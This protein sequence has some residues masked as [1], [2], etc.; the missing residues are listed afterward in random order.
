MKITRKSL[1]AKIT[2]ILVL[3]ILAVTAV[4]AGVAYVRTRAKVLDAYKEK[5]GEF[6]SIGAELAR[7]QIENE[8]DSGRHKLAEFI[9]FKY[10]ELSVG[11]C[12]KLWVRPEDR[13][14]LPKDY[15]QKV[16]ASRE[17]RK[18]GSIDSFQR[19]MPEYGDDEQFAGRM[20]RLVDG[21]LK[22]PEVGITALMDKNGLVPF[23]NSRNS[24]KLTGDLKKDI[25]GSR[26]NRIWDYLGK[27]FEPDRIKSADYVRDTGEVYINSYAP[28]RIKGQFW[29]GVIL[30]YYAK[31]VNR[32][33]VTETIFTVSV[34]L[35][36]AVI[37]FIA[38]NLLITRNL[39]PIVRV[40]EILKEVARGD[41]TRRVDYEG[42]DEVGMISTNLNIMIEQ[43]SRTIEF[44]KNAA[45]SL[46]ASSEELTSTSMTMG[47]SST[48]QAGSVREITVELNLVLD[49]L[50]ETT[51][52]INEQVEDVSRA[53]ESISSLE[54]MSKKIAGNMQ[55]VRDQS[56]R[57]MSI[58]RDGESMGESTA[59]A[60][61]LIVESSKRITDMVNIINDISD[62]INLLS[63]NASIEA[64]RAGDA[65]RG[66]AVVADE[67]GKLADNTS[68]QV[69]EIQ[70][71][72]TEIEHNVG[73]GSQMVGKIR[74][75]IATIMQIIE[76]NSNLIEEIAGLSNQQ[77][78]NH[79]RIREVMSRLEEKAANIIKVSEFQ[80]SN[81]ESMKD[82]M[83]RIQEFASE[84]ASGAEEIA[85]SSE[86]LSSRAEGLHQ[87]IEGFKTLTMEELDRKDG[88]GN[89]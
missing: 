36:G 67:I 64:A 7:E 48:A 18:D 33:I 16:F 29:G 3:I 62:K 81:S 78:D 39:R 2:F 27:N 23:H 47:S 66:F 25:E 44:L 21:F 50:K 4:M 17:T 42:E 22:V 74:Q 31:D 6:A 60:M 5:A 83:R 84:N 52:Y 45:T 8:I 41:F 82:A 12:V 59:D 14:R 88:A 86:E 63:L 68:R 40:S 26:T 20:R 89:S 57:S 10:K 32:Q 34:I 43:S 54:D 58:S 80:R 69:K 9:N 30:A 73:T 72:S 79:N 13:E 11:E 37:I 24:Q 56:A 51:E 46:A 35:I 76:N 65:G 55:V 15:L 1:S 38:L 85:A 70:T 53:A 77:A 19:F 87:L 61:N 75:A 49:S 28:I 71:L